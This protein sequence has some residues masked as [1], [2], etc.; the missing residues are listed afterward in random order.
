MVYVDG[1]SEGTHTVEI[2]NLGNVDVQ[3]PVMNSSGQSGPGQPTG[4]S[5]GTYY[6][7]STAVTAAGETTLSTNPL[8]VTFPNG[9]RTVDIHTNRVSGATSYNIYRSSTSISSG[10]QLVGNVADGPG[11]FVSWNDNN[12]AVPG[13]APP[14]TSTAGYVGTTYRCA[15]VCDFIRA[16]GLVFHK[17]AVS[18]IS[19]ASYFSASLDT[20][21]V[22]Q[23]NSP[24][25]AALGLAQGLPSGASS[26]SYEQVPASRPTWRDPKLAF[27][28][29]GINDSANGAAV[30]NSSADVFIQMA[31]AAGADPVV[32]VPHLRRSS[33]T[34]Q[35][36]SDFRDALMQSAVDFAAAVVD[37]D[38]ALDVAYG[39]SYS[40]A[41]PHLS[42]ARYDVEGQFIFDRIVNG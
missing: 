9:P 26:H 4:F 33:L 8:T 2:E 25:Q 22:A 30:V 1:L 29:L 24:A 36:K 17:Q 3:A 7:A 19:T 37:L 12:T 31:R 15:V 18:G 35:Q 40:T 10:F 20:G 23:T 27:M 16:A 6:Y 38:Y 21:N 13:A 39:R 28:A 5:S 14:S 32:V 11:S 41:D 34:T 42:Q